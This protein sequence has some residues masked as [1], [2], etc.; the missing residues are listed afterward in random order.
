LQKAKPLVG[1]NEQYQEFGL[2]FSIL[3]IIIGFV[4]LSIIWL[5]K[6][7]SHVELKN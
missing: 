1:F 5:N 7:F 2:N 4:S 3:G 6:K